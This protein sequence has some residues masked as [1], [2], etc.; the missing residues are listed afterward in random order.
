MQKFILSI[1]AVS[2][3]Y[4]L[5]LVAALRLFPLF[6]AAPI[7]FGSIV[8]SVHFLNERSRFKGFS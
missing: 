1:I 3:G 5:F 8:I 2:I 4:L 7:F 6:I